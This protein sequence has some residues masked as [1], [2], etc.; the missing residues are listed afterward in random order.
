[1]NVKIILLV[2]V[3]VAVIGAAGFYFLNNQ[4]ALV[5]S[6]QDVVFTSSV[7]GCAMAEA[8]GTKAA[9]EPLVREK[10]INIYSNGNTEG[11]PKLEVN[12]NTIEYSRNVSHL[13]CRKAYVAQ[14]VKDAVINIHEIWSGINCKCV[15]SSVMEARLENIP[16]GS[17]EVNVYEE[18]TNEY[19]ME[20]KLIISKVFNL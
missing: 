15:C 4:T 16:A 12:G 17:Y 9:E 2:V 19:P 7:K 8:S 10:A 18:G 6:L 1:M 20:Q 13:C 5:S 11:T 3:G 14:E